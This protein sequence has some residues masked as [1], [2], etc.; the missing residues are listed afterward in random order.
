MFWCQC[1]FVS[2]TQTTCPGRNVDFITW[3][4][5]DGLYSL[6]FETWLYI[7]DSE[8]NAYRGFAGV[9]LEGRK[10]WVFYTGSSKK[11]DGIWNHYN[12]KSTR[13]IYTFGI[14]KCTEKF[15]VLDVHFNMCIF[16][17]CGDVQTKFYLLPR[18]LNHA[19]CYSFNG[20]CDPFLQVLDIPHLLR[21]HSVLNVPPQEKIKWREIWA[22]RWPGY[23]STPSNPGIRES[24]N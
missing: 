15:E 9:L 4:R 19:S 20:W 12:L 17:S 6:L 7:R 21:T 18:F 23:W 1:V 22:S 11:M 16:C 2:S 8:R 14:L 24:L 13:R 5:L 3:T 10:I